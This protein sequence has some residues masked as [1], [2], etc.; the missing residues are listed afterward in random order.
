MLQLGIHM[1]KDQIVIWKNEI[2]LRKK[3]NVLNKKRF[4]D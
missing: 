2:G 3:R 4:F 1:N